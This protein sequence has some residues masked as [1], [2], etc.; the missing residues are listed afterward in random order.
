MSPLRGLIDS[1]SGGFI[2]MAPL[3]GLFGG[4]NHV[5]NCVNLY[6]DGKHV[7]FREFSNQSICVSLFNN[8]VQRFLL[9]GSL[10]YPPVPNV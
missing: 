4:L 6:V 2:T 9:A 1:L 10:C 7:T 5:I 8:T 3:P